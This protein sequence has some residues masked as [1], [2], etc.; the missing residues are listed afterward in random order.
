MS[1]ETINLQLKNLPLKYPR[2]FISSLLILLQTLVVYNTMCLM[3]DRL[4][5]LLL[6]LLS[7]AM[8]ASLWIS[9][10][11]SRLYWR[12]LMEMTVCILLV[13]NVVLLSDSF[14]L[15]LFAGSPKPNPHKSHRVHQI[16]TVLVL[17]SADIGYF[18]VGFLYKSLMDSLDLFQYQYHPAAAF[19]K[20]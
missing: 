16:S 18:A 10:V 8:F 12:D 20:A 7:I 14:H 5:S 1:T 19:T 2:L 3:A 17:L 11:N 9:P 13:W 4:C 6:F 15:G